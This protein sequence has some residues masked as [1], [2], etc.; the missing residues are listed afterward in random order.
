MYILQHLS[1]NVPV[2]EKQVKQQEEL[3]AKN[4]S[5]EAEIAKLQVNLDNAREGI[6]YIS[7]LIDFSLS[8][9]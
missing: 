3:V 8:S 4:V 7:V 5:D 2:L 9:N 1:K 6:F